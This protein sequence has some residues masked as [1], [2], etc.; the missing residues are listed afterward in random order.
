MGL[1]TPWVQWFCSNGTPFCSHS[2]SSFQLGLTIPNF[3]GGASSITRVWSC[4]KSFRFESQSLWLLFS[5]RCKPI[6][7]LPL[8]IALH[9]LKVQKNKNSLVF[10]SS[11]CKCPLF[12]GGLKFSSYYHL[13]LCIGLFVL[14]LLPSSSSHWSSYSQA[15]TILIFTMVFM[16]WSCNLPLHLVG[17]RVFKL[18]PSSFSQWLSCTEVAICLFFVLVFVFSI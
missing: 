8:C 15:T 13:F 17:L 12:H 10:M 16:Y 4:C 3:F 5:W 14:K 1:W 7:P 18:D 9:L 6:G 11:S 2:S